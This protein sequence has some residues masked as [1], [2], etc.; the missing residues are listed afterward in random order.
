[1]TLSE[2]FLNE[3]ID[4][5]AALP[6]GEVPVRLPRLLDG[7]PWASSVVFAAIP[8]YTAGNT[9]ANLA[10]FARVRD[11]HAFAQS[12]TDRLTACLPGSR[13]VGFADH[14]PFDEIEGAC[15]AGLGVRGDNGL[16]ITEKYGSY[17]FLYALVTDLAVGALLAEGIPQGTGEVK[18]CTHCG[19]CRSVCPGSCIGLDRA[20]CASAISQKKGSLTAAEADI[21]RRAPYAWGCDACQDVCPYT[22]AAIAAGTIETEIPYFR[23]RVL[24]RVTP[25]A[26]EAMTEEEYKSYAFGWRKKDVLI[27]NLT[28]REGKS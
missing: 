21:L 4:L 7:A 25:A 20:T 5:F 1:M 27:R 9:D 18:S 8:Y 28:I 3:K 11:Y 12:L 6:I 24:G 10:R 26:I 2:C 17:V 23:N 15:R 19:A 22:K 16:L 13:A 14:S